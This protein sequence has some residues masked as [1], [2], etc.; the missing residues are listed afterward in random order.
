M[1]FQKFLATIALL[2]FLPVLA[3]AQSSS[4]EDETKQFLPNKDITE[5]VLA[6][7]RE[8]QLAERMAMIEAAKISREGVFKVKGISLSSVQG[9]DYCILTITHK[10]YEPPDTTRVKEMVVGYGETA[11]KALASARRRA[12]ER[13][14]DNPRSRP[15]LRSSSLPIRSREILPMFLE[16]ERDFIESRIRFWG[17]DADWRVYLNIEYLE[18]K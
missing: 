12:L 8:P 3:V 2:S 17:R 10:I 6:F 4:D 14:R 15:N 1:R 7:G 5:Q 16:D 11:K 18:M 9:E 13:I